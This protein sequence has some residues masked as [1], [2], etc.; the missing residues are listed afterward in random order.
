MSWKLP[1]LTSST[2]LSVVSCPSNDLARTNRV[3]VNPSDYSAVSKL[4]KIDK[5]LYVMGASDAVRPSTIGFNSIQRRE[6]RIAL[7]DVL[8]VV[9]QKPPVVAKLVTLRLILLER[10]VAGWM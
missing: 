7:G 4:A 10:K 8:S 3:Y 5:F 2:K 9:P 1:S 6:L